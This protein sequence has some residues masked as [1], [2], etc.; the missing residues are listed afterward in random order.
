MHCFQV[1]KLIF[2][3]LFCTIFSACSKLETLQV[4]YEDLSIPDTVSFTDMLFTYDGELYLTASNFENNGYVYKSLDQGRNLSVTVSSE[5]PMNCLAVS[6]DSILFAG[7]DSLHLYMQRKSEDDWSLS[8]PPTWASMHWVTHLRSMYFWDW[9]HGAC[10]GNRDFI[11]GNVMFMT[12]NHWDYDILLGNEPLNSLLFLHDSTLLVV[13]Y[14]TVK[15]VDY[16]SQTAELMQFNGDNLTSVCKAD[17][18]VYACSYNGKVYRAGLDGR[19]WTEIID[20][21]N[22]FS[23]RTNLRDILFYNGKLYVCGEKGFVARAEE[24]ASSWSM[25][26]LDVSSGFYDM[27]VYDNTLFLCGKKGTILKVDI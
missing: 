2:P 7:G 14:G 9:E 3:F 6:Q 22:D 18:A 15:V 5:V 12:R 20:L 16:A 4:T 23:L 17:D 1:P 27:E 11:Y 21:S 8:L 25:L 10:V 19:N 24:D 26:D 13:G